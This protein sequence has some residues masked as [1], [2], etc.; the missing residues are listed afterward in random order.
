MI[1]VFD[2][3]NILNLNLNKVLFSL[4]FVKFCT[5]FLVIFSFKNY[6]LFDSKLFEIKYFSILVIKAAL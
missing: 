5:K 2:C 4:C 6:S 3:F 1:D